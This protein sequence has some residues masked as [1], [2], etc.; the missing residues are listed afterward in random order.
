MARVAILINA[1]LSVIKKSPRFRV[2]QGR[3]ELESDKVLDGTINLYTHDGFSL[4]SKIST[5]KIFN[6]PAVVELTELQSDGGKVTV[7]A[8]KLIE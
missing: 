3:W 2:G 1:D 7:Y 6:G 5:S 4:S 8:R